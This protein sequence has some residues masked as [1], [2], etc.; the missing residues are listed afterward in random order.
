MHYNSAHGDSVGEVAGAGHDDALLV[1]GVF[2]E[3]GYDWKEP[4][5]LTAI[6]KDI[7]SAAK[8]CHPLHSP[9]LHRQ[10]LETSSLKAYSLEALRQTQIG[11]SSQ[12]Y[13]PAN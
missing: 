11:G 13:Q 5:A 3:L 9:A 2:F 1:V 12:K 4:T 6:A 10:G 7:A 8:V